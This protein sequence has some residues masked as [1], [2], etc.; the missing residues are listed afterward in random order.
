MSRAVLR[1]LSPLLLAIQILLVLFLLGC[2]TLADVSAPYTG[3]A[4]E[5]IQI[6]NKRTRWSSR[7][8][9]AVCRGRHFQCGSVATG[10]NSAAI[11]CAAASPSA[12]VELAT[13]TR[14][15]GG[16]VA[17]SAAP[18]P[19]PALAAQSVSRV[20]RDD[21]AHLSVVIDVGNARLRI[22]GAPRRDAE[23]VWFTIEIAGSDVHRTCATGVLVDGV[24][25]AT[26]VSEYQHE[27]GVE[28]LKFIETVAALRAFTSAKRVA[29]RV[30][31]DEWR[32]DAAGQAL[33]AEFVA[34][35]DEEL[36][37]APASAAPA[38]TPVP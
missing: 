25:R 9:T 8:W 38:V 5:E 19:A 24:P 6:I 34:R 3:C 14:S 12:P 2:T 11:N 35:F 17:P 29:G 10:Q 33:I 7:S 23:R 31:N 18:A 26:T 1:V 16:E 15:A 22:T 27:G 20:V 32:L 13:Q 37:W 4:P 36:A 28:K 21:I 30:C